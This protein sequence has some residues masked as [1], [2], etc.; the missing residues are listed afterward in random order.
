LVAAVAGDG[1]GGEL[2]AAAGGG[3]VGRGACEATV[4]GAG[5]GEARLVGM[6][7]EP[8]PRKPLAQN[9]QYP[10]GVAEVCERHIKPAKQTEQ[11]AASRKT[12]KQ[13]MM[14]SDC[15][16]M[17]PSRPAGLGAESAATPPIAIPQFPY[18]SI[19]RLQA[20]LNTSPSGLVHAG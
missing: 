13:R 10:L 2:V 14:T 16:M 20:K 15:F 6:K 12:M 7:C 3:G 4:D 8:I 9:T 11:N 1:A 19:N 17:E 5:G 18:L